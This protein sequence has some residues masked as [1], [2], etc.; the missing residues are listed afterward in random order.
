MK[1]FTFITNEDH[2]SLLFYLKETKG[3]LDVMGMY[4]SRGFTV[5]SYASYRNQ[6]NCFK[7]LFEYAWRL[8]FAGDTQMESRIKIF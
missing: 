6:T 3:T 8:C 7:I 4:D 2:E 1:T 5:L